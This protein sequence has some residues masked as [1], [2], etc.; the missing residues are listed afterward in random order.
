VAEALPAKSALIEF[1]AFR[2]RPVAHESA[3]SSSEPSPPRYLALL[4]HADG[5]TEAVD[6]GPAAQLDA[7]AM[8][9]H[10]ALAQGFSPP[11][12]IAQAL[13]TF[14]F[15][16]LLARLGEARQVFIAPDGWVALAPFTELHDGRGFLSEAFDIVPLSSGRDLLPSSEGFPRRQPVILLTDLEAHFPSET[17]P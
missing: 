2:R 15:R 17:A 1:V 8:L 4:L 11:Q 5:N 16:P 13:Y 7:A 3:P 6:L 14:A 12:A 10:R 9:L